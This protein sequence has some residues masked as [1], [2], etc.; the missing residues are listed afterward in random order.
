MALTV[1]CAHCSGLGDDCVSF[2]TGR[3]AHAF[4][5]SPLVPV[6]GVLCSAQS[7]AIPA[8]SRFFY[9]RP[10]RPLR[11]SA[12]LHRAPTAR[13]P[14]AHPGARPRPP[15]PTGPPSSPSPLL[16]Q[17]SARAS[18][19][20]STPGPRPRNRSL[21]GANRSPGHRRPVGT[22]SVPTRSRSPSLATSLPH[23]HHCVGSGR[24][25]ASF[26]HDTP[27]NQFHTHLIFHSSHCQSLY[28][29][30]IHLQLKELV[31][32]ADASYD[33][34][35]LLSLHPPPRD[36]CDRYRLHP[37][38]THARHRTHLKNRCFFLMGSGLRPRRG[39]RC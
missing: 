20:Q 23:L 34:I 2:G 25:T 8:A 36:G 9:P 22:P 18:T 13:Q 37:H 17:R 21:S 19:K 4:V 7:H 6:V 35:M 39:W 30:Y 24:A 27:H 3:S 29:V 10:L 33:Q 28:T 12:S 31:M 38:F 32:F 14:A 1:A 16:S 15:L 26:H 11:A 5:L